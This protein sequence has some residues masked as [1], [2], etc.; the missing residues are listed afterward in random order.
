MKYFLQVLISLIS[1]QSFAQNIQLHYDLR[2]TTDPAANPRNFPT[3]YFE[4]F[5]AMDSGKAFIKPGAFLFKMQ[6]DLLG[7]GNNIGKMYMQV[8][9]TLRFWKPRVFLHLSYSGGLGVT[10]PKQYSYYIVNT[11]SAGAAYPFQWKGGYYTA[12]L[13][14]KYVPYTKPSSDL[15]WTFY[16]YR[17]FFNYHCEL[18]GD[19]SF[20]TENTDHGDGTGQGSTGKRFF[21]YGEPQ[22]WFHVKGGFSVGTKI[23]VYYHIYTAGNIWQVYPAAAIRWKL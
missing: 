15:L 20:W 11:W 10:E 2:H 8:A 18:Q 16:F 17:G 21:L 12:V 23:N 19:F 5:K 6:A 14:Y 3:L 1:F 7:S 9:Q 22:F 4:Y 13:D